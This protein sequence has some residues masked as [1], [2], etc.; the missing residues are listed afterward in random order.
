[1]TSKNM[2]KLNLH[3]FFWV[4]K[5][6]LDSWT[7][8]Y[9]VV[10]CGSKSIYRKYLRQ[11]YCKWSRVRGG[12]VSNFTWTGKIMIPVTPRE[13]YKYMY[14]NKLRNRRDKSKWNSDKYISNP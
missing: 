9:N 8:S 11:L 3:S 6:M 13:Y 5:I 2:S 12:K 1:M 10:W 7:N 4:L 14:K